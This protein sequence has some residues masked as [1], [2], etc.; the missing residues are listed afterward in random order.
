MM[1][2]ATVLANNSPPG[3][4]LLWIGVF[5][6]GAAVVGM[7]LKR[8][9]RKSSLLDGRNGTRSLTARGP[10]P[11]SPGEEDLRHS[12]DRLLVELQETSREI[13]A[14]I[15]TKTAVLNKLIEDADRRIE[16]LKALKA[17]EPSAAAAPRPAERPA[18]E[19]AV[20]E[21]AESRRR[22]EIER[23]VLRLAAEGR[24]ELE[25]ARETGVPRGEVELLLRLRGIEGGEG[26]AT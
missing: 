14:T 21:T 12:M 20:L 9:S 3:G 17:A 24:T 19:P 18:P 6:A 11:I 8:H 5:L 25:I 13:N 23:E 16:T 1:S 10:G 22:R 7:M 26:K 4:A 15:D 2:L